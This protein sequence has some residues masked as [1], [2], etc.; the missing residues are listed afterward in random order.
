[1]PRVPPRRASSINV[2]SL[3]DTDDLY[4][5]GYALFDSSSPRTSGSARPLQREVDVYNLFNS[6]AIQERRRDHGDWRREAAE[7]NSSTVKTT[8]ASASTIGRSWNN[9]CCSA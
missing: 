4:T 9:G 8:T 2:V 6:D 3:L 7:F 5:D 1:M